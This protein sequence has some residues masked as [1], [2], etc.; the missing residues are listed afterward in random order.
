M[1]APRKGYVHVW[2]GRDGWRWTAVKGGRYIACS[3][4]AYTKKS[5]AIK[6][7][8]GEVVGRDLVLVMS[9]PPQKRKRV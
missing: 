2:K 5:H 7:A 6:M 3:G 1:G 4:E 9:R 8:F